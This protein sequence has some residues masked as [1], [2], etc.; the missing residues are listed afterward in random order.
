MGPGMMGGANCPGFAANAG[1][2]TD[3]AVTEDDAK[4]AATEYAAKYFPAYT[5]ERVLRSPGG[6]RRCIAWS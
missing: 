2:S 3:K 1:T 6:S 5:V 4:K